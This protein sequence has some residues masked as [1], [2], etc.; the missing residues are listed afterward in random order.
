MKTKKLAYCGILAAL[1]FGLSYIE[2][3][4][5]S[6]GIPGAKLG[7]AN[8]S[9]MVA[10]YLLTPV[11]A[12]LA[13]FVRIALSWLIFGSFTGFVYSLCGSALSLAAMIILKNT[14]K[15]STVGVSIGGGVCHNIGQLLAAI[16]FMGRS[17]LSYLPALLITGAVTGAIIGL[18][19]AGVLKSLKAFKRGI[20]T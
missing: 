8:L 13:S 15:F 3:M 12:V 6:L 19:V 2:L 18:L 5:P 10:L 1:A 11:E 16:L 9:V 14:D 20:I 7:L 17:V 4:L